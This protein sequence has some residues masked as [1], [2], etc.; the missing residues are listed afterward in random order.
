M[1]RSFFIK[2]RVPIYSI[3]KENKNSISLITKPALSSKIIIVFYK[4]NVIAWTT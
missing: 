3:Y 4:L 2:Y 1:M